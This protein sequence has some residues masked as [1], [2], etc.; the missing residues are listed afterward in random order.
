MWVLY[1]LAGIARC[2][3]SYPKIVYSIILENLLPNWHQRPAPDYLRLIG[4]N[5]IQSGKY[6]S[7]A[8][9]FVLMIEEYNILLNP[10]HLD[11]G[12]VIVKSV[13]PLQKDERLVKSKAVHK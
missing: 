2:L 9:P 12:K 13:R 6:L 10:R 7:M 1:H 11:F 4:D 5:F 8:V 3:L